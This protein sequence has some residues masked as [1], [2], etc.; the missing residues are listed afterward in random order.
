MEIIQKSDSSVHK[1]TFIR[2]Q[3]HQVVYVL[4]LAAFKLWWQSSDIMTENVWPV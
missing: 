4:S 3:L 1:E 2:T